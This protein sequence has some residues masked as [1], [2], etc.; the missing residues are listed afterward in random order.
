MGVTKFENY[1][2]SQIKMMAIAQCPQAAELFAL[3]QNKLYYTSM[4][5]CQFPA[6]QVCMLPQMYC[7]NP[8]EINILIISCDNTSIQS[9]YIISW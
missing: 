2:L 6:G 3:M 1:L 9:S 5:A 4:V 7:T 8:V